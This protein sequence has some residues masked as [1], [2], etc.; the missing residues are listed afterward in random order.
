MAEIKIFEYGQDIAIFEAP[1]EDDLLWVV[2][3]CVG[4]A[5]LIVCWR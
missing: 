1:Y 2:P 3:I 5:L 4:G